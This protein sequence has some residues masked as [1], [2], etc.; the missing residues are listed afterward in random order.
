MFDKETIYQ[1]AYFV[2]SLFAGLGAWLLGRRSEAAS[3][4]EFDEGALRADLEKIVAAIKLSIDQRL[5]QMEA[6][7]RS[8]HDSTERHL[9]QIEADQGEIKIEMARLDERVKTLF[10]RRER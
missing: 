8:E 5:D 10:N 2:G 1:I 4:H 7:R 9:R 6:L 3:A